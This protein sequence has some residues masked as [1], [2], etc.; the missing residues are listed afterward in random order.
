MNDTRPQ[1]VQRLNSFCGLSNFEETYNQKKK[2]PREALQSILFST[3]EY[4][5]KGS[6]KKE[7]LTCDEIIDDGVRGY[8]DIKN[9]NIHSCYMALQEFCPNFSV[10][11]A[12]L[13]VRGNCRNNGPLQNVGEGVRPACHKLFYDIYQRFLR[14][15]DICELAEN[16]SM[17]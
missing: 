1:S 3:I 4:K 13:V 5:K 17:P 14:G 7:L 12:N 15:D 6:N 9:V 2:D 10:A 8:D 11:H 16:F